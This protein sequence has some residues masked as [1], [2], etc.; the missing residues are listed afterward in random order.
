[1]F[2]IASADVATDLF[3]AGK[4]GFKDPVP[5]VNAGTVLDSAWGNNV[6][7]EIANAIELSGITLDSANRQQLYAAMLTP[8]QR[9]I[10]PTTLS[11]SVND[12]AP[13]SHS[14]AAVVRLSSSSSAFSISGWAAGATVKFKQLI[15]VSATQSITLKHE[16]AGST[17]ANR[18]ACPNAL[19]FALA[20]GERVTIYYD[21]TS[22]RWRVLGLA[23]NKSYAFTGTSFAV[24]ALTADSLVTTSG[25]CSVATE[26]SYTDPSAHLRTMLVP[27]AQFVDAN[28]TATRQWLFDA[29]V[30]SVDGSDALRISNT[31]PNL[32][33]CAAT[34]RLPHGAEIKSVKLGC[35]QSANGS[36]TEMKLRAIHYTMDKTTAFSAPTAT[37]LGTVTSSGAGD[38]VLTIASL[39]QTFDS[40]TDYLVVRV[41]SSDAGG[42][43][44]DTIYWCEIG[45]Y[46]PGPRNY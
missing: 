26:F 32:E 28:G 35:N 4:N 31:A 7:E 33:Q 43:E 40:S 38:H 13:T 22:L 20:A 24:K 16:D 12:Y 36:T 30:T 29:R 10:T 14:T 23:L 8:V 6:Q 42:A 17:A 5:G 11:A 34:V 1:M 9:E 21:T 3:G 41:T 2:R 27:L 18:F 37:L 25:G 39:S 15:N 44:T 19:D 45:F 46:D